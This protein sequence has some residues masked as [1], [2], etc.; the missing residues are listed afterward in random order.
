MR[1]VLS[2][3]VSISRHCELRCPFIE[4]IFNKIMSVVNVD[5]LE[6]Q[7]KSRSLADAYVEKRSQTLANKMASGEKLPPSMV[8][9]NISINP[10]R[11]GGSSTSEQPRHV[12]L[13]QETKKG[14]F[15]L[16]CGIASR[17]HPAREVFRNR[18]ESSQNIAKWFN[19]RIG[20]FFGL[21]PFETIDIEAALAYGLHW[22]EAMPRG[23]SGGAAAAAAASTHVEAWTTD[24]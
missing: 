5:K 19:R 3:S 12:E 21:L 4:N 16:F 13:S 23:S 10:P 6:S 17:P 18:I 22:K 20:D 1:Q 8:K 15:G 24:E 14:A 11:V 9:G 7:A 2:I